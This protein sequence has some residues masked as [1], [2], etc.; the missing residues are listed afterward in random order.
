MSLEEQAAMKAIVHTE[1]GPP[2]VLQFKEVDRP[3]AKENEVLIRNYAA[4]VA[5]EDTNMRRS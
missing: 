5:I 1:H 2:E 4:A 3:T